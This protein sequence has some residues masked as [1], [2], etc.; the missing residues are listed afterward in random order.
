M[1]ATNLSI[2]IPYTKRI[3]IAN[4][5]HS[6]ISPRRYYLHNAIGGNGWS[7]KPNISSTLTNVTYILKLDSEFEYHLT[8]IALRYGQA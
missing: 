3:D 7:L 4:Y 6:N 1:E 2:T 5:C 8:I